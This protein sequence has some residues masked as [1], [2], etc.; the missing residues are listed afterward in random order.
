MPVLHT[1]TKGN[2]L[3]KFHDFREDVFA[4]FGKVVFSGWAHSATK[5][6]LN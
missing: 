4:G 3:P 5:R 2:V 1:S 6:L